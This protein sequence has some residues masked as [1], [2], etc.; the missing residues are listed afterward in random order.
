MYLG[1]ELVL[2]LCASPVRTLFG[3]EIEPQFNEPYLSTSLQDFWGHRW[4]LMVTRILRLTIY[5]PIRHVINSN[6]VVKKIVLRRGW[7]LHR[8]ISGPLTLA[9][10]AVTGNWLF[11]PQLERNGVIRKAIGEYAII[12]DFVKDKLPLHLF[13]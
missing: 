7:R 12:V 10:L 9:F 3:F 4:N 13:S 6:V 2:A 5:N 11:F 1:L 8:A